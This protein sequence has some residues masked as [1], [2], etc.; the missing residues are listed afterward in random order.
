MPGL[1]QGNVKSLRWSQI[2]LE[3]R[4]MWVSASEH[5]NGK[6]H[7]VPLNEQAMAVLQKRKGTHRTYVF[8]YEGEPV[9][10]V[11]TK[12]WRNALVRA[13]IEDFR[14]HDLRHTFATWHREVGTPT[15]ELQRLGGWRIQSMVERYAHLAPEGLQA[16][17]ARL[18]NLR[19][20]TS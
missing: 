16:A 14:W 8:T 3:R 4:H 9:T 11:S 18:D 20:V 17:A 19:V 13:G 5:K 12:A 6:A 7:A 1:R 2:S 15:H 10:Q